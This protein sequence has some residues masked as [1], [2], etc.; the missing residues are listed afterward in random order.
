MSRHLGKVIVS[1][2]K[3][4]MEHWRR[5]EDLTEEERSQ[6]GEVK[7]ID[8]ILKKN[9][10]SLKKELDLVVDD[11]LDYLC[12]ILGNSSQPANMGYTAI[13]TDNTPAAAGQSA[14][15]AEVMRIANAYSKD[16]T[17]GEASLDASFTIT[18]TWG[19]NECCLIN[20]AAAGIMYCRDTFTTRNVVPND[21]VNVN[22]TVAFTAA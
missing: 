12:E 15:L 16:G 14:L 1:V 2:K 11:G 7:R 5:L 9:L 3:L 10:W 17:T 20:A 19:L 6:P 8:G 4:E 13:G 18:G 22:Y 21:T